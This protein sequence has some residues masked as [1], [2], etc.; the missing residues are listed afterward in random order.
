VSPAEA[1]L[2][3]RAVMRRDD[4]EPAERLKLFAELAAHFREIVQ[5]P[6]ETSEGITDEQYVRN[7][8][9]SLHRRR[10]PASE[11]AFTESVKAPQDPA[12]KET[13]P[14]ATP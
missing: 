8:V 14:V 6:S 2:A 12:V 3:L 4:I 11:S 1:D 5:F 9:D 7:V 10:G 13:E